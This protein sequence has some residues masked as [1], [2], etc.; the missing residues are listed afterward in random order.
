[1]TARERATTIA[2]IERQ[3]LHEPLK[4]TRNRKP[5]GRIQSHHGNYAWANSESSTR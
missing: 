2:A 4:E 1:L 3:L 5:Y